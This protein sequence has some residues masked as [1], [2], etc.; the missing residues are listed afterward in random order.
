MTSNTSARQKHTPWKKYCVY[1]N[2]HIS[3]KVLMKKEENKT[4]EYLHLKL[5]LYHEN[6]N[7]KLSFNRQR[8]QMSSSPKTLRRKYGESSPNWMMIKRVNYILSRRWGHDSK[9]NSLKKRREERK[10]KQ[11]DEKD[12]NPITMGDNRA[13]WAAITG[14]GTTQHHRRTMMLE[15]KHTG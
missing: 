3:K 7:R 12:N 8:S 15:G 10:A 9:F 5:G 11:S 14:E 6:I 2:R 4:W 13:G 1:V